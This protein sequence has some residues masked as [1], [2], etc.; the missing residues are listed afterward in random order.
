M[1]LPIHALAPVGTQAVCGHGPEWRVA[2]PRNRDLPC[3]LVC[4]LTPPGAYLR[5]AGHISRSGFL[6]APLPPAGW[7]LVH[8]HAAGC[9][10]DASWL[11]PQDPPPEGGS[12][13]KEADRRCCWCESG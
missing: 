10:R 6:Q 8:S 3:Q 5:W 1:H 13:E 11:K 4:G 12:V 2:S 9:G 7:A